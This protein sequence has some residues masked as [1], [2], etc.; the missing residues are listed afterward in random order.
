M[1][2][3]EFTLEPNHSNVKSCAYKAGKKE[4]VQAHIKKVHNVATNINEHVLI[5][6]E[7]L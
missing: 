2:T 5:I 4:N 1:N 6:K 3:A 7:E